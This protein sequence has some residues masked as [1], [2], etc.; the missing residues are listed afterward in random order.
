MKH[1]IRQLEL[2]CVALGLC[3]A[4]ACS[5]S[6]DGASDGGA[7]GMGAGA[8]TGNPTG[9]PGSGSGGIDSPCREV[10][11]SVPVGVG[12][13]FTPDV[14]A[15]DDGWAVVSVNG[16]EIWLDM[17]DDAAAGLSRAQVSQSAGSAL[18]P[19]IERLNSGFVVVWM[20]GSDVYLRMV[21]AAGTPV[22]G[23]ALVAMTAS[24]EPRPDAATM[25]DKLAAA[26][27]QGVT[28]R[29]A[30]L[31]G[32]TIEESED[33]DGYFPAVA[34]RDGEVGLTWSAGTDDGPIAF[35]RLGDAS[36]PTII[37]GSAALIKDM[38]AGDAG[39][40]IA[41]EDV[42]GEYE[43]VKLARIAD[44][45]VETRRIGPDG[46]SANWPSLAWM[47]EDI[48][49]GYYQFRD[50][51]AGVYLAI[52]D[53]ELTDSGVDLEISPF[54][55]FPAVAGGHG[56]VAVAYNLNPGPVEVSI[57]RCE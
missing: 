57:V 2:L 38:L 51:P 13:A 4:T 32:A 9:G 49:I 14:I 27:M 5:D 47:G 45:S 1:S 55:K 19:S 34:A 31:S 17:L 7:G 18:L 16:G 44:T 29:A 11:D 54:A 33:L 22:G 36:A 43:Q 56:A 24:D 21:S 39:Y 28:S 15:T 25:G 30:V 10:A 42:V 8:G 20:Q 50:G 6:E 12:D 41:W 3:V 40:F 52:V 26:W 48:A 46:W 23:P 37:D 35:A 53:S